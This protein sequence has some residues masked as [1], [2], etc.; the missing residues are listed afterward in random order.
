[1]CR[2][3]TVRGET[4]QQPTAVAVCRVVTVRGETSQQPTAFAVRRVV[5]VRGETNQQP[6][7][8]AVRRVADAVDVLLTSLRYCRNRMVVDD[9]SFGCR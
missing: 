1:M 5:T 3:V 9:Y 8:V 2:V 4:S 6:T 7:A